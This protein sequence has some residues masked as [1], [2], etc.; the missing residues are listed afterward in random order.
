VKQWMKFAFA[1]A[2]WALLPWAL[3]LWCFAAATAA[4][5]N[6]S[7]DALL[8]LTSHQVSTFVDQFSEV[9]CTEHVVQEKI[10]PKDKIERRA[11]STYDYLVILTNTGGELSL[12]ESRLAVEDSK[13]PKRDKNQSTPLLISNGFATLFL[14]FHPY[15]MDGYR[16]TFVGD[17]DLEGRRLAKIHFQHIRN[18]RSVAALA[19]RGREY[20]LD[21]SGTAWIDAKTG[22]IVR[23]SAGVDSG[24]ED[25]GM[26]VLRSEVE[27]APVRF[28]GVESDSWFPSQARVEVETLRQHWRNTHR[29]S[30]YK[31]FSVSTE[32]QVAKQ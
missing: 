10:G 21:L 29:F 1:F 30:D 13:Q 6:D 9:K 28:N 15:Y 16:F 32:E 2:R 19:V 7:L 26:K 24:V 12:D 4:A 3:G 14:I 31:K 8:A 22:I 5:Q 18:T 20:P 23:I 27:F 25:I 11:E 17:E